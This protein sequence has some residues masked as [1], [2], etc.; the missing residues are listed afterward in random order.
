MQPPKEAIEMRRLV[1]RTSK[2]VLVALAL[3]L[4]L[5]ACGKK[6][7]PEPPEGEEITYPR[8]YPTR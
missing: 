6:G 4:A 2:Q 1:N 7:P 8:T 3:A 5:T